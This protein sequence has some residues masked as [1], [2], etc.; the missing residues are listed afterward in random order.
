MK[1]KVIILLTLASVIA[2]TSCEKDLEAKKE[3]LKA[4]KKE[5]SELQGKITSL[6]SEIVKEDPEFGVKKV[7]KIP[8]S[9]E[10]IVKKP[11]ANYIEINGSVS[12]D[13]NITLASQANGQ[14][15]KVYVSEGDK[16]SKGQTLV[17]LDT[18]ILR[19]NIN[20]AESSYNLAKT[21]YEK[22]KKLY[23]QGVGSEVDYLNAKTQKETLENRI[24][25]LKSQ[26][27]NSIVRAPFSGKIDGVMAK[28]G[29]VAMPGMPMVRIV[30]LNDLKI[31]AD[32]S[33][34]YIGSFH[35]GDSV[36]VFFP[37]LGENYKT[38]V[39]AVGDVI[40]QANRT[41]SLQVRVPKNNDLLKPNLMATIRLAD[42]KNEEAFVIPDKVVLQDSRGF[43][44]YQ[45]VK[46]EEGLKAEKKYIKIGET[47][48]GKAEI[49][50]GLEEG[51]SVIVTGYRDV[52]EGTI[53]EI[54]K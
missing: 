21:M 15:E 47:F 27:S 36:E 23:D 1:N 33:E 53:V 22:R 34:K 43:Y 46:S 16:V 12:T 50:E 26:L 24:A 45:T 14:I 25:S 18:D 38:V 28:E 4:L 10:K 3:E 20:E 5:A 51:A 8:V 49:S 41:F 31:E 39:S 44:V 2:F 6:E 29:E 13:K 9:V 37:A 52:A 42:Y 19:N 48:D 7:N 35:R 11:F 17:V 32:V 40:N 54:A 30:S